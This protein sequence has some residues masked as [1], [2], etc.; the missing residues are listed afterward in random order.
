MVEAFF[1]PSWYRV[2]GLKPRIAGHVTVARHRYGSQG[3]YALSDPASGRV[4][5]LSPAA[6]LFAA[7]MDGKQT[8]DAIWQEMVAEMDTEAPGQQAVISLLMQLHGADLLAGDI[9]PDA[10]ELLTR[11]DRQSRS[12]WMRNLRSPLSMQ[13]P[14]IDPD[15]FLTRTLPLVRPLFGWASL[16]LWLILM[17]AAVVTVG[18]HWTELTEN[19]LDRVMATE[20]LFMLALCYPIMKI[21]HE[22]GHGYT[23]KRFGCEVHEMGVMLLVLFPVPYVDA[24]SSA[25]LASK[26]QRAGV[27]AAGIIVELTMAAIAALVW[28][29]AEPGV[30][31]AVA[32]NVMLIGGVSTLLI[33]GNPLLRFDGYYVLSD[34]IEVP[35]LT[36]RGARYLGYLINR[37][38]FR[39]PGR[40]TFTAAPHER[41]AMIIYA[42]LA[43]VY[44]LVVMIGVAAYVAAHYFVVGIAIG[45]FT[46]FMGF[47]RPFGKALWNVAMSPQYRMCRGRAAGL[48]FGAIAAVVVVVLAV[49]APVHTTAEG[50]IWLPQDAIVRA[51]TDGFVR[52]VAAVPGAHVEPGAALF[53]LEHPISE[54][55]LKVTAARVQ[56]LEAKYTAEWV[57]DRIAA[58]VTKFELNQARASLDREQYRISR[59]SITALAGGTFNAIRPASNMVGRYVKDGEIMGYVTPTSGRVARVV[60]PQADIALVRDHLVDVRLRLADRLTDFRSSVVRAVPAAEETVPSQALTTSN[61]G[62]ISTDPRDNKG[63]KAFER[64]FQFDVA[65]PDQ[66]GPDKG[67]PDSAVDAVAASGFGARVFVRFDFAWESLG[68]MLYR[69]TRQALLSRFEI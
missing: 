14:L 5:R 64:M 62:A 68:T 19:I 45:G 25:A 40:L 12:V 34:V 43:W 41:V 49:P 53:E 51:G 57:D 54:A 30:L 58:E 28:V 3:W 18:E 21:L 9:P 7:R 67:G 11:R 60:V 8:V 38:V 27:A 22:L 61:G 69:R 2:A 59:Q 36:Q 33:N 66:N 13:I 39:V 48:T 50:I 32:Y 4:H 29:S 16:V 20:G 42:P 46:I 56:E 17:L 15:R 65:L 37:Y 35:N 44:R 26:W 63:T 55:K 52:E 24:S 31:R 6:Y 23:A 1:S 10:T 47:V